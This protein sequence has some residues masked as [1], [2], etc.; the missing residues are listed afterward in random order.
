MKV[1]IKTAFNHLPLSEEMSSYYELEI[2]P[3]PYWHVVIST[4]VNMALQVPFGVFFEASPLF[5][6]PAF[7]FSSI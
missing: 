1:I 6:I 3:F 7:D 4:E 2:G 5:K